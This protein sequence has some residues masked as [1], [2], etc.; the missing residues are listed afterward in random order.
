ME[1]MMGVRFSVE[2]PGS[3]GGNF[4]KS[5]QLSLQSVLWALR[6]PRA[7]D[8]PKNADDPDDELWSYSP[9]VGAEVKRKL[10]RLLAKM[11]EKDRKS[12]T[13][14]YGDGTDFVKALDKLH[15]EGLLGEK[16]QLA[17]NPVQIDGWLK[18]IVG[19]ILPMLLGVLTKIM[20]NSNVRE[21]VD[22]FLGEKIGVSLADLMPE[23]PKNR[24]GGNQQAL[25]KAPD[26]PKT[27]V[28][29]KT[30]VAV[31]PEEVVKTPEQLELEAETAALE[32]AAAEAEAARAETAPAKNKGIGQV[33]PGVLSVAFDDAGRMMAINTH[34][35]IYGGP[36][37]TKLQEI[38]ENKGGIEDWD[39]DKRSSAVPAPGLSVS[40]P[41]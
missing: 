8:I 27:P 32:A 35:S 15:G 21:M 16:R 20:P 23:A 17:Q 29:A 38:L 33:G 3:V 5:S 10:P 39:G 19:A 4:E 31:K 1:D 30:E 28:V 11:D 12:F 37:N 18:G 26:A 22:G 14:L 24:P 7:L 34:P 25:A 2:E 40:Q 9:A 13:E 6:G 41:V 36:V